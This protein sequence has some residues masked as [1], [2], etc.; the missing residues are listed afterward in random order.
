MRAWIGLGANLGDAAAT[1]GAALQHLGE[2]PDVDVVRASSIWRTAPVDADGPDYRNAVAEIVT[3][4]EPQDLLD[5]LLAIEQALG[6]TRPHRNAPRTIDLDLL[7]AAR[8]GEFILLDTPTL[9]LP[10]PRMHERAF[11]LAPLAELDASI[12]VPGNRS[13]GD[14]LAAFDAFNAQRVVREGPI[15]HA[16]EKT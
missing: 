4:L 5:A 8:D 6:R 9:R 11:V 1:L 3:T 15:P 14:A 13:V 10:H 2:R 16:G 7:L 12:R